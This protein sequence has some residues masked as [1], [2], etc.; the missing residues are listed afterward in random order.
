MHLQELLD[1]VRADDHARARVRERWLR[2]QAQESATFVGAL[3]DLA[4]AQIAVVLRVGGRRQQGVVVGLGSD[5]AVLA[6]R[7]A[8]VVVRLGAVSQV[9]PTPG[10]V[11]VAAAGDRVAALDLTFAEL[12]AGV[13]ADEPEVVVGFEDGEAATGRLVAAGVDVI[14]LRLS[15]G[16]DGLAYCSTASLASVRF[17]SG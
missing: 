11:T 2:Q 5:V 12:L 8:H 10:A 9:R 14:T 7:D 13:A 4:E 15:P 1:V 16:G 6:E 17:R 3:L